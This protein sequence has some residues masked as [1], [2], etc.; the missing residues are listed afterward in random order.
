[1]KNSSKY[2]MYAGSIW[3]VATLLMTACVEEPVLWNP[4]STEQVIT[5]YVETNTD[6]SEFNNLLISTGLNSLLSVRGPFTLF[7]PN[8][9]AMRDF[10]TEKGVGSFTSFSADYQRNLVLNHLIPL[11]I[12][13]SDIGLGALRNVNGI[14]DYLVTEFSGS[15]IILNKRSRIVRRNVQTANGVVHVVNKVIPPLENSVYD[16]VAENPSFSIFAEGL[17]RTGLVDTLEL[18]EFPF[19]NRMA[20][21]RYTLFAIADTTFNRFGVFNINDLINKYTEDPSTITRLN[22]G[23]YR[24]MEYH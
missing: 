20:R 5:Q 13:T 12:E 22:N 4:R 23:F 7:L 1:M 19:G 16:V 15:D 3:I 11:K 2:I 24:Y 14:G 6:F 10:Y 9:T 17:R 21:T 18:I 8:N